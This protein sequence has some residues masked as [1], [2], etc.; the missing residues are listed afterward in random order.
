MKCPRKRCERSQVAVFG[1]FLIEVKTVSYNDE[2]PT[3]QYTHATLRVAHRDLEPSSVWT[4]LQLDPDFMGPK[5]WS[6]TSENRVVSKDVRRHID[7][8]LDRLEGREEAIRTLQD[9]GVEMSVYCLWVSKYG[10]GGPML[11]PETMRRLADL[12]FELGFEI[13]FGEGDVE[14]G[15]QPMPCPTLEG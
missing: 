12:Q 10:Q 1:Q 5:A 14:D 15:S 3:C 6:M 8:L 4:T 2:Y 7:W 13:Y 11:N 9:K